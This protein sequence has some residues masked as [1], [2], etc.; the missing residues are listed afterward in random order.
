MKLVTAAVI[1]ENGTLLLARRGPGEQLPGMWELPGGKLEEGESP[2]ECL[3]RELAEELQMEATAG[4]VLAQTVYKYE[5]GEFMMIALQ[6]W[7]HS[8]YS[9]SVHDR[10][11]WFRR[12]QLEGLALAP[13]D[14]ELLALLA[15]RGVW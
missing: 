8:D 2:Q 6:A 13:A 11:A 5:H 10:A 12:E 15:S 4:G 3:V 1:I 7:R 9:L 14:V